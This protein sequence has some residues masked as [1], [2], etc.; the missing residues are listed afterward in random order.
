MIFVV[1][2][3]KDVYGVIV[4]GLAGHALCTGLAVIGGRFV[5]QRISIRTGGFSISLLF[6]VIGFVL[7]FQFFPNFVCNFILHILE[8][9]NTLKQFLQIMK[10]HVPADSRIKWYFQAIKLRNTFGN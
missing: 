8:L 5:A 3:Q 7:L 2:F 9:S 4:G 1:S 10:L 6:F